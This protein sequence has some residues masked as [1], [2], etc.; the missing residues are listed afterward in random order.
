MVNGEPRWMILAALVL[1]GCL[2]TNAAP[3]DPGSDDERSSLSETGDVAAKVGRP[4]GR[5]HVAGAQIVDDHGTPVRLTGINWFGLET[6]YNA[7][8][9]LWQR[10]MTSMLD[11]IKALGFN[12]IRVPFS[13]Q[14]FDAGSMP[15]WLDLA[16]NPA[17][18]GKTGAEVLDILITQAGNRDLRIILDRHRPDSAAQSEL[19]YTPAY[20][21][22][23]WI[24]DWVNLARR[25][26]ANPT[27]V[28][29][30]LHNE[31]H[32]Q[33]T[34]GDGN[35]ATDWRLAAERAGNA[36][37][38]VDPDALIIV[39]GIEVAANNWYW[40]GGNLRAAMTAPVELAV[41]NHVIYSP[42]DYPA[43]VYAQPWFSAPDYPSN[44]AALWDATWGNLAATAPVLVG[45]FGTKLATAADRQWLDSLT[46]YMG[47]RGVSFT[48]WSLNADSG[49]TGG[50]LADDW[51]TV[52]R[53]KL[54]YLTPLLAPLLPVR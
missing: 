8:H 47:R 37:L 17:L 24:Q 34:W 29:F 42:H 30:D 10:S 53:D 4:A 43:S 41:P 31:P 48:F 49:D 46:R 26:K 16:Q 9:G 22:S 44:L 20:S 51:V 18:A 19:W 52:N 40:W 23:R 6:S 3:G 39:E 28:A 38:A 35:L 21:E 45:E 25:Y 13:S 32:G 54:A 50:I 7:P 36:I 12:V 27:V 33:A 11:Q 2:S 5:L 15:G 1:T 14:L